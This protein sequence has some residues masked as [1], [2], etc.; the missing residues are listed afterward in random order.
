[1]NTAMQMF[2][3]EDKQEI[4]VVQGEDGEPWFVAG[5]VCKVLDIANVGNALARLDDDEK[6]I[7]PMDTLGGVQSMGIVTEAGLYTLILRS[8]KPEAKKFKRW[9]THEV[10]P[11]IRKTGSY[12]VPGREPSAFDILEQ[13]FATIKELR[14]EFGELRYD[15]CE[16][17]R[18]VDEI[19]AA[20]EKA[21]AHL[22]LS[23]T[24]DTRYLTVVGFAN[25]RGVRITNGDALEYGRL[26]SRW[27]RNSG[28]LIGQV[29]DTR[30]GTVNTY[31]IDA[32]EAVFGKRMV[33]A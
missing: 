32:L 33:E 4:R 1:M 13:M 11:A 21:E 29:P 6:G 9:V 31:H 24:S 27:S 22:L 15:V 14:G 17:R 2:K 20:Q 28:Y 8:K 18:D 7:R 10:L 16:V 19:K 5:D 12:A 3:F 30:F 26:A 25:A 23:Q